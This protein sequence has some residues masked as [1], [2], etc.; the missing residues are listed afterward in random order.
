[1]NP[2]DPKFTLGD[3]ISLKLHSH[4]EEIEDT[5][6]TAMKELKIEKKLTEIEGVWSV[7]ELEYWN[8][9]TLADANQIVSINDYQELMSFF[10]SVYSRYESQEIFTRTW[11]AQRESR[12]ISPYIG[13]IFDRN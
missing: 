3:M 4:K 5:V 12:V 13:F 9:R 10:F 6:E 11:V 7:M 2:Q 1:M 8:H